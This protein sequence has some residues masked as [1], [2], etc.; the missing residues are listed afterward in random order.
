MFF[1]KKK[2][3]KIKEKKSYFK[4]EH[5]PLSGL[6]FPKYKGNYL[7]TYGFTSIIKIGSGHSSEEV[8]MALATS[9]NNKKDTIKFIERFKEQ[10]FKTNVTIIKVD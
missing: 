7:E 5:Y 9:F 2:Q 6:Y 4:I 1:K 8:D 10:K 3:S